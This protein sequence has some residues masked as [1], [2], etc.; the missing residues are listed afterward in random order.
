MPSDQER[1]F[2]EA[3]I[4]SDDRSVDSVIVGGLLALVVLCGLAVYDAIWLGHA[5]AP[6]NFATGAGALL[7]AMGGAKRLRDG[8]AIDQDT[9]K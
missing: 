6:L 5:F 1:P 4:H 3:L 2:L 7:G 8:A 9:P